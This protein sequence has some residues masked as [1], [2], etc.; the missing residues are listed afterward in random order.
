MVAKP[1]DKTVLF[2]RIDDLLAEEIEAERAKEESR[3][4]ERVVTARLVRT[5]L[6]E[7]LVAR[8]ARE[9]NL[10]TAK[11]GLAKRGKR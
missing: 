5:L 1:L 4:F 10:S 3:T 7:A 6:R 11:P 8:A 2:V 9:A